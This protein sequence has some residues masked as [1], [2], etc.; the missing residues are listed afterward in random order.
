MPAEGS[1]VSYASRLPRTGSATL[2]SLAD[3]AFEV[4]NAGY[5]NAGPLETGGVSVPVSVP[6][7]HHTAGCLAAQPPSASN[8]AASDT[9][10][11]SLLAGPISCTP[12]GKP[13]EV[14]PAGTLMDGQPN[15]FHGQVTGQAAIIARSVPR[16][17]SRSKACTGGGG[18]AV[19]GASTTS[20][21]RKIEPT[22]C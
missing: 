11:G 6:V 3:L 17:L 18:C 14:K 4:D 1:Q 21:M 20:T 8:S 13:S 22:R 10:S 15:T 12:I 2:N 16:P 9:S 19:V 7:F 5:R